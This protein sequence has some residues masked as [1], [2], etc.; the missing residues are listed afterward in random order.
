MAEEKLNELKI[1]HPFEEVKFQLTFEDQNEHYAKVVC[2]PLERGFGLTLGNAMRR[3]LLSALPG[4]S[5]YAI[6]V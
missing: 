5:V 1:A 4:T 6:E 3:V 2:E